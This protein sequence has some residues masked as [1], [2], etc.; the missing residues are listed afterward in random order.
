MIKTIVFDVGNVVW[1]YQP[2]QEK[3]FTAW[4]KLTNT[5]YATFYQK[6][7]N[8]YELLETNDLTLADYFNSQGLDPKPFLDILNSLYSQNNFE[9]YLLKDT[10]S[11]ISDLKKMGYQIGY[12]SNA[13]N[14]HY[15]LIHQRLD[16]YFDFG[17]TSWQVKIRKPDPKIFSQIFKYTSALPLEVVFI[18]DIAQNVASAQKYGL[19]AI[20]FQNPQQLISDLSKIL[21][22]FS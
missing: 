6:Y 5:D 4:A 22:F 9:K 19:K 10:L 11:L 21:N 1:A 7:L 2:L 13:E 14:Y 18:D 20:H 15:P 16:H 3:L 17:I 12:L 8:I